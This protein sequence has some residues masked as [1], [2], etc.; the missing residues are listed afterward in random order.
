M[1]KE[2]LEKLANQDYK[3]GFKTNIETNVVP[4]GLDESVV[5]LISK[6]KNEPEFMLDFRLKAFKHWK[7]MKEPNWPN[8]D[9]P[10]I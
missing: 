6:N 9:M 10:K 8:V 3:Y 7:T 5:R 4:K 1:E 2:K